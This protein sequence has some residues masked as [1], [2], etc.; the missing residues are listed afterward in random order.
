LL[1]LVFYFMKKRSIFFI[2]LTV[3]GVALFAFLIQSIGWDKI[4]EAFT[5]FTWW[6]FVILT[7][8][9]F[10]WLVFISRSTM[11]ILKA[12]G[13]QVS[14]KNMY[15]LIC[16][17]FSVGYITPVPYTG[18]EPVQIY[19][20]Y[21]RNHVPVSAGTTAVILERVTRQTMALLVILTGVALGLATI[22][23]SWIIRILLIA[24]MAFFLF[25]LWA[26]FA[27]SISGEGFLK[28]MIRVLHLQKIK[29]V[30][31]PKAARVI[32][33]IDRCTTNFLTSHGGAFWKSM[34]YAV[35]ST[36]VMVSQLVLV[37]YFMGYQPTLTGV[38][39]LYMFTNLVTLIPTPAMLGTYEAG[40]M[41][42]FAIEGLGAGFGLVFSLIIRIANVF[43]IVPGLLMLPYYGLTIREAVVNG[44]QLRKKV[45]DLVPVN[46]NNLHKTP[47]DHLNKII[48]NG[49]NK[50]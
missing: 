31:K 32:E 37:L 18:G 28:Y 19:L 29:L 42:V 5:M 49:T 40:G 21:K 10:V 23:M 4:K 2:V 6:Q 7:G 45:E 1:A 20:M 34:G 12:F 30:N 22:D 36:A 48:K 39:L 26:Y 8:S 44:K 13:H 35:L 3:V 33:N 47:F 43:A 17:A 27:K 14:F 41:A 15:P 38:L 50:K 16:I 9:F 11:V 25:A 24:L 46:H